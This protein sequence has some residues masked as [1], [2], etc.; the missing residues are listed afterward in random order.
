MLLFES[1]R[2]NLLQPYLVILQSKGI[3]TN[4]SQLKQFLLAKFVNEAN[5]RSLSL[6]SNYYLAG[7]ARYYFNGDLTV[8]KNVNALYPKIVDVFN[9]DICQKLSALIVVLRNAYIDSVGT[10]FEQPE[11]FGTLSIAK[12]LRKYNKAINKELGIEDDSKE[13]NNVKDD[14]DRNNNVGNGYTFEILHSYDEARKY[15]KYTEPDAWCITYGE[16]HFNSYAHGNSSTGGKKIHYVIFRKNGYENVERKKGPEW[17][18]S[19]PQDEYGCSL[20]ALLQWNTSWEPICITSR[21][22]HGSYR[23]NSRC[24]ADHAFTTEEFFQKTGVT[25]DDLKRIFKIWSVDAKSYNEDV[26]ERRKK[27]NKERLGVLRIMKYA[28][29]RIN[30]G[31]L[32]NAFGDN[33]FFVRKLLSGLAKNKTLR[34]K[35]VEEKNSGN[36]TVAFSLEKQ[37]AKNINDNARACQLEIGEDIYYFLMDKN[38]ILFET[39]VK[40]DGP[41]DNISNHFRTSDPLGEHNWGSSCEY[42]N[43]IVMCDVVNGTMIYDYRRHAFVEVDGV[44]KF[45]YVTTIYNNDYQKASKTP[46]SYGFYEV[47]MSDSQTAL[48]NW[49][50]NLPLRLPN[51]NCWFERTYVSNRNFYWGREV[52]TRFIPSDYKAMYLL[53]DSS[54]GEGYF[55]D[56]D[57]KKFFEPNFNTDEGE[58]INTQYVFDDSKLPNGMYLIRFV[59]TFR[60]EGSDYDTNL[61][62]VKVYKNGEETSIY[63]FNKFGSVDYLGYGFFG[64]CPFGSDDTILY[65]IDENQEYEFPI[66]S[67]IIQG[68]SYS[69]NYHDNPGFVLF[70]FQHS[71]FCVAFSTKYKK[72]IENPFEAGTYVIRYYSDNLN[73]GNFVAYNSNEERSNSTLYKLVL[74]QNDPEFVVLEYRRMYENKKRVIK[75]G[76]EQLNNIIK[77]SIQRNLK[78]IFLK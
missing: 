43:N 53:Y 40:A 71:H 6:D 23:D 42:F 1:S 50:T 35:A 14:I 78:T 9:R 7:V 46:S 2:D 30:G 76:T 27:L 49:K 18:P 12:L 58:R 25:E 29:M 31:N 72:F 69:D 56:F 66:D 48:I 37:I 73:Y 5:I 38:K 28:Q 17:T 41:Y 24:E 8:N 22:N 36:E 57:T 51:G 26:G 32:E 45:K 20:I 75:L 61:N 70:T 60:K 54:S 11:D 19:K 34:E 62:F 59:K 64:L 10:Q 74:S 55:Y 67:K 33:H 3:N 47:K 77:E 16:H 44:K 68:I 13:K 39:I 4:L 63:G 15:N 21:W 52:R 65:N